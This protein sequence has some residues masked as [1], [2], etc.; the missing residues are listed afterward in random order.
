MAELSM[1][2]GIKMAKLMKNGEAETVAA[3]LRTQ[4]A[5]HGVVELR[6]HDDYATMTVTIAD[7]P[8]DENVRI[9]LIE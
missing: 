4:A 3:I 9:Y 6:F 1:E 5:Q 8:F 2:D 7:E